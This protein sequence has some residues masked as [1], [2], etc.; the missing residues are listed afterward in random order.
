MSARSFL[1][2]IVVFDPGYSCLMWY[3]TIVMKSV[4][5]STGT[6]VILYVASHWDSHRDF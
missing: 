4:T 1:L 6:I 5:E 3:T 2:W